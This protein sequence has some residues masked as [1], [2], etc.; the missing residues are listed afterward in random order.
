MAPGSTEGADTVEKGADMLRA[1]VA[2]GLDEGSIH[3]TWANA[4]EAGITACALA[5][6]DMALWDLRAKQAGLTNFGINAV[7]IILGGGYSGATYTAQ[8][9]L[10]A[11]AAFGISLPY[12]RGQETEAD[13]IGLEYMARAGFDPRES[14][15]LWQRMDASSDK[16]PAEFLSTHP[17]SETRIE[18]LVSQWQKTL[19]LYN[20]A[21]AEGRTPDCGGKSPR[22]V[23]DV[24]PENAAN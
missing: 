3:A 23:E 8:Q 24:K 22:F 2:E 7:A 11:G 9:A 17:A 10:A 19:P 5:A 21:K 13:V 20:Q 12:K 16:K 1:F 14:V 6:L 4:Q 15:P 18:N